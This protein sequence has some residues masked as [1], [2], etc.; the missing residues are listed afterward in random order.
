MV[1]HG[2]K[3]VTDSHWVGSKTHVWFALELGCDANVEVEWMTA[4][5]RVTSVTWMKNGGDNARE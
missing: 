3:H 1:E 2:C 4:K 5:G